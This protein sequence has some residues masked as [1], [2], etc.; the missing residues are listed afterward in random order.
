MVFI[1][2][3]F[4]IFNQLL[5]STLVEAS[6]NRKVLQLNDIDI[7]PNFDCD[8]KCQG[9]IE[10]ALPIA[11]I[12]EYWL[13]FPFRFGFWLDRVKV[14]QMQLDFTIF[15]A[16]LG[17]NW[18]CSTGKTYLG[19]TFG[20]R[21]ALWFELR[22]HENNFSRINWTRVDWIYITMMSLFRRWCEITKR[23]T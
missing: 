19:Y 10:R 20:T 11:I 8:E 22:Y 5:F 3:S 18:S 12:G 9:R 4:F 23:K 14:C 17:T 16:N 2:I 15:L 1:D 7:V 21:K 13:H 6:R